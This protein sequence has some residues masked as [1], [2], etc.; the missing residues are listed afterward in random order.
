VEER[1]DRTLTGS[2][3]TAW[4]NTGG[5]AEVVIAPPLT[6]P[7]MPAPSEKSDVEP[8][9]Y[10]LIF[11]DY[12]EF[13][14]LDERV[15]PLFWEDVMGRAAEVLRRRGEVIRSGNTWGDAILAVFQDAPAA[16]QAALD[17]C[18]ELKKVNCSALGVREG[19]AMRIALHYGPNY[20]GY[21]PVTR[22]A[23]YYGTEVSRAA[24][25][26][27]VTPSGAVYVTEPIAAVLE[28]EDQHPFKCDYVGKIALPKGYGIYP[29][30]RLS[31]NAAARK[32]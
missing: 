21:D 3:V 27:P 13:S 23:T 2:D 17:L 29:L 4:R 18:E 16:A 25:I 22:G 12:P 15:L 32:A 26:E 14:K 11:T 20:S 30:Y 19:A 8:G 5:R 31:R 7:V 10:G 6:R 24:P 1:G 28:M 9:V